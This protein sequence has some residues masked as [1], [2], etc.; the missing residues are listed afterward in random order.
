MFRKNKNPLPVVSGM[1]SDKSW[2]NFNYPKIFKNALFESLNRLGFEYQDLTV[3]R[4]SAVSGKKAK[5]SPLI[6]I[7]IPND[8]FGSSEFKELQKLIKEKCNIEIFKE[9]TLGARPKPKHK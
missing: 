1:D 5:D 3:T 7:F 6:K 4:I 2:V 9:D 8:K